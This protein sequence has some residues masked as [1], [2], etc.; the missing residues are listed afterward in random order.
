[1]I[2]FFYYNG[3]FIEILHVYY[4]IDVRIVNVYIVSNVRKY[5]KVFCMKSFTKFY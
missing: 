5:T 2:T 3:I 1:M 4:Y